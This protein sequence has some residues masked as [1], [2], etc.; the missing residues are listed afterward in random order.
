MDG[1]IGRKIGMTQVFDQE[2]GAQ[3]PVTVIEAGPCTVL[4]VK[5]TDS[6]GYAAVQLGFEDI[7]SKKGKAKTS[8][9]TKAQLGHFA[10]AGCAPQRVVR[11]FRVGE[12]ELAPE[13]EEPVVPQAAAD[14]D[15]AT[16]DGAAEAEGSNSGEAGDNG[17]AGDGLLRVGGKLNVSVFN[18]T[19]FV[20]VTST[21]KGRGFQG[22]VKRYNFRGGRKTHGGQMHRR[23]GSI[24]QCVSP[25]RVMKGRKMPGHMGAKRVTVQ[26]LKVVAVRPED[27]ALLVRGA[28]PGPNG[29]LVEVKKALKKK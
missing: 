11:E 14:D 26:N 12:D 15:A 16:E 28:V 25:A 22:V 5:R 1:L 24:G 27:N 20:D 8:K 23:G 9:S 21:S 18:E 10:K 29:G 6:D 13:G 17:E 4:Q 19:N 2:T 7:V 3:I